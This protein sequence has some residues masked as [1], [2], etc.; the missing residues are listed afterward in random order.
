M[1]NRDINFNV[2]LFKVLFA[3]QQNY[4]G[5]ASSLS[6][7]L[8]NDAVLVVGHEKFLLFDDNFLLY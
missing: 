2:P 3:P 7:A 4:L 1:R 6:A 8:W 5:A